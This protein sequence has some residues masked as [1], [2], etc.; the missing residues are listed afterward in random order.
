MSYAARVARALS[1][2]L[3]QAF[4]II[5][6]VAFMLVEVGGLHRKLLSVPGVSAEGLDAL[7]KNFQDVRRYVSLKSVMSLLTGGLVTLWLW[8][9]GID[10]ALFMGLLAFFLNFVPTIGSFI[11]AVPGVLLGFILIGPTMA[12][13]TAVGYIIINVGVSN[14]IEPRFMARA[15]ASRRS[16]SSCPWSFG[17]GCSGRSVCCSASPS[18]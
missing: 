3:G 4:L 18:P 12:A 14:V 10:N 17:A 9:L 1:G 7:D 11:A 8:L 5:I 2:M 15:W 16:L 6:I 13:V